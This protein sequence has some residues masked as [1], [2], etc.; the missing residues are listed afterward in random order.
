MLRSNQLNIQILARRTLSGIDLWYKKYG[1]KRRQKTVCFPPNPRR[2][3]A[4]SNQSISNTKR[5]QNL[6]PKILK[7]FRTAISLLRLLLIPPFQFANHRKAGKFS[8]RETTATISPRDFPFCQQR[9][10][11][12]RVMARYRTYLPTCIYIYIL[13]I[14]I[15]THIH[16]YTLYKIHMYT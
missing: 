16:I 12:A 7:S 5:F 15:N 6:E 8:R 3:I 14:H 13:Y 4:N 11:S 10:N 9:R 1:T 2:N